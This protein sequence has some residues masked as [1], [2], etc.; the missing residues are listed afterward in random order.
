MT[1][2]TVL[3]NLQSVFCLLFSITVPVLHYTFSNVVNLRTVIVTADIHQGLHHSATYCYG[4]V[5]VW[6]SGI[7]QASPPIPP[8]TS[9]QGA[10]FLVNSCQGNFCCNPLA[11]ASLIPKL[12]LLF[13]RV[14][15]RPLTRSPWS[16][17]PDHLCRFA[18]RF[19]HILSL[20]VFLGSV[21]CLIDRRRTPR[22]ITLLGIGIETSLRIYLEN[23]LTAWTQI[24]LM[25]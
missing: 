10:V 20:E 2:I 9:S 16:T 22:C 11:W 18:V 4:T 15:W 3:N 8:L 19:S 14:P 17:R 13:C 5:S 23:I 6:P 21:L 25:R 1:I 24:H 12:R 7:G